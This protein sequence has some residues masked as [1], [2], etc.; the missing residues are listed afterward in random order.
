MKTKHENK[1]VTLHLKLVNNIEGNEIITIT[2][3]VISIRNKS[4]A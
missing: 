2:F 4:F 1:I 3:E